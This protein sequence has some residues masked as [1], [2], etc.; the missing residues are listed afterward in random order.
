MFKCAG[1]ES[2][3]SDCGEYRGASSV[4]EEP[5]SPRSEIQYFPVS[6]LLISGQFSRE[7]M[8]NMLYL[9]LAQRKLI[10]SRHNMNRAILLQENLY[11]LCGNYGEY[12]CNE[13]D[14][15]IC[16]MECKAQLLQR[17][18]FQKVLLSLG[19]QSEQLQVAPLSTH[20]CT[21]EVPES[22]GDTW[23][24]DRHRW[25]K[26]ISWL[27]TYEWLLW[28]KT[29]PIQHREIF[30]ICTEGPCV[31]NL[32]SFSV[33][34]SSAVLTLLI[35]DHLSEH[36][37]ENQIHQQFYSYK[38]N[39]LVKCCKSTCLVTSI[40]DLLACHY[41]FDKAFDK[42][43]D[44]YSATC[45]NNSLVINSL[46]ALNF[47][48][49]GEGN[50]LDYQ[51]LGILSAVKITLSGLHRMNCLNANVEDNAYILKNK[52]VRDKKCAQLR[53]FMF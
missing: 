16:S 28:Y 52:N 49:T 1:D 45:T 21:L 42:F 36:I 13:T 6:D 41:C 47:P 38:L 34:F 48:E 29:D 9:E 5:S 31:H 25:S 35:A 53:D 20:R 15:D 12:I 46:S 23:D 51:S 14:D 19:P 33:K 4:S 24:H 39:C 22:G 26:K 3:S 10:I 2:S 18:K 30:L 43:Y 32:L 8:V 27:C 17:I 44:M 11:A 37:T 40:K 50:L 7:M